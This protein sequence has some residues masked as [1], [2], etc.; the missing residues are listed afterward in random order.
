[1]LSGVK[2]LD[3]TT[4]IM[5]PFASRT[6]ADLGADVIKIEAP[7]G[8][9]IRKQSPHLVQD[10]SAMFL[11]LNRNKR[12]VVLDLKSDDG[13]EALKALIREADV[14]MHNLRA[15]V[16]RRLGFDYDVC[17]QIKSDIVYCAAYGF[18][19]TGPYAGKPAYDDLIQAGSGL[20]ALSAQ[21]QG[22]PAYVPSVIC[23][24]V[25]GQTMAMSILAALY[26]RERSG[27]GQAIEVPM[28]ETAIDFNLVENFGGLAFD[29]PTGASGYARIKS[30]ERRPFKTA[31]GYICI[32]P[33]SDDNW[34]DFFAHIGRPD[35][36]ADVR[37]S[38][39]ET[40]QKH[41][42]TLYAEIRKAAT[43]RT[44]KE[45]VAWCDSVDIPC[46][47][48]LDFNDLF[49]D[50]HVKS[51][52]LFERRTHPA[53]GNYWLVRPPVT[54][55]ASPFELRFHAPKLG[56]HTEQVL[57]EVGIGDPRRNARSD[58]T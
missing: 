54:Y 21:T 32:L 20:A 42:D 13:R 58:A 17:R 38:R 39:M 44:T 41:F 6:L 2:I 19:A 4:V 22:T 31:D 37:Y 34:R 53:G 11:N 43:E 45:W 9:S 10:I 25:A 50:Q 57:S 29:P 35:L 24:K 49:D 48:V 18:S 55:S 8:D 27:E 15:P 26:H 12:S 36:Q 23:D 40:R 46:M 5:G 51:I 33:Y 30:G 7:G 56:E 3:L 28:F 14:L 47:P 1:M 16:M 52:R